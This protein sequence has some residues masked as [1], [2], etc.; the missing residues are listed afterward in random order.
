M[1]FAND[2]FEKHNTHGRGKTIKIHFHNEH[3]IPMVYSKSILDLNETVVK[4][5]RYVSTRVEAPSTNDVFEI[6]NIGPR[7]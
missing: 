2:K 3:Q 7:Q 1:P 5:S 4:P 6:L